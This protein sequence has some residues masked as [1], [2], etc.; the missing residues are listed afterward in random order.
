MIALTHVPD[1]P[2]SDLVE[3]LWLYHGFSHGREL[4]LP[5]GSMDLVVDLRSGRGFVCGPRSTSYVLDAIDDASVVG[6]H[7]RA[8]G[9]S[10]CLN[11]PCREVHNAHVP[12]EE[13]WQDDSAR[14]CDRLLTVQTPRAKFAILQ[15]FLVSIT[16][17]R[18]GRHPLVASALRECTDPSRRISDIADRLGV[19]H[20]RLIQLFR[21]EV[22]LTP[23]EFCRVRRF[24]QVL[25]RI[26]GEQRVPWAK[27]AIDCGYYD[28]AHMI[29]D[30][31]EF[32]GL[33]P[34]AYLRRRGDR[35]YHIPLPA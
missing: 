15:Q 2:I 24:G 25:Q 27:L 1:G 17:N 32:S 20:R 9:A 30:F 14:L 31:E 33:S 13:F 23:K 4:T 7:F 8:G 12:M 26:A 19:S 5:T 29:N 16:P 11:F 35:P 21:D 10:S 22:G 34:N 18:L 28:Q 6:V 3:R